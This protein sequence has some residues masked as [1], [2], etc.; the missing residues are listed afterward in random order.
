MGDTL[1]EGDESSILS[2]RAT[3]LAHSGEFILDAASL[4]TDKNRLSVLFWSSLGE[5]SPKAGG[6]RV[7]ERPMVTIYG[8]ISF[9]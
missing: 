3:G 7:E 5:I 8:R 4:I 6:G 9:K 1:Q 2:V